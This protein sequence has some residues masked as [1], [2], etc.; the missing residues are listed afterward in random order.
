MQYAM[1]KD[2]TH[3]FS[4]QIS[5]GLNPRLDLLFPGFGVNGTICFPSCS[6]CFLSEGVA[7]QEVHGP[8][9]FGDISTW[10]KL[11]MLIE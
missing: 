4:L 1:D 7:L 6:T 10:I 2:D 3:H 8:Q 11:F 5:N 9:H